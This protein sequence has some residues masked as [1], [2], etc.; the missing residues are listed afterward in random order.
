M[1]LRK[2]ETLAGRRERGAGRIEGEKGEKAKFSLSL[3]V[4]NYSPGLTTPPCFLPAHYT[5][6]PACFSRYLSAIRVITP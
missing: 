1:A 3:G 6:P 5:L 2:L 4:R